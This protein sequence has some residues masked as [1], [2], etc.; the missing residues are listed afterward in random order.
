MKSIKLIAL[1]AALAV[2]CAAS[3]QTY[4]TASISYAKS[5]ISQSGLSFDMPGAAFGVS[6]A[7]KLPVNAPVLYEIGANVAYMSGTVSLL[8]DSKLT[9]ASVM[10]PLN[11]MIEIDV[12]KVKVLPFA[13]LNVTGHLVG[14]TVTSG[15]D[16][17]DSSTYNWF[18]DSD[19]DA[20]KRF[21]LGA[22]VG[23]KAIY[24]RF[25]FGVSYNPYLTKLWD[26]SSSNL[27]LISL[28]IL[29]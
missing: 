27:L 17:V 19:G 2:C 6:F 12:D 28:G 24:D 10:I 13:G 29:F 15:E 20:A 16:I 22:Q 14:K 7:N 1:A 18:D 21:Q 8:G 11:L 3:A 5:N 25:M 23:V 9:L 4:R 26:G